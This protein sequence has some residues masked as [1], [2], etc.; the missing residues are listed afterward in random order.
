MR[1]V[2]SRARERMRWTLAAGMGALSLLLI[3]G[4]LG[5]LW[6]RAVRLRPGA[7]SAARKPQ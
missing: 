2:R 3:P 5:L 1:E 6:Q 7:S 4:A